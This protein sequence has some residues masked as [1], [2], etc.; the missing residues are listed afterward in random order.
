MTFILNLSTFAN[1]DWNE[2]R[3]KNSRLY[4]KWDHKRN[5]VILDKLK[6]K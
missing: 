5:E 1:Y 3:V 6:I 2:I 4:T